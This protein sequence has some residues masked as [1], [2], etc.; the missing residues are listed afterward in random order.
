MYAKALYLAECQVPH[1]VREPGLRYVK[2]G[3]STRPAER[4]KTLQ[5]GNPF[6]L[7]II[8]CSERM[9]N[10]P[11][12][13]RLLHCFLDKKMCRQENPSDRRHNHWTADR[14]EWFLLSSEQIAQIREFV[15]NEEILKNLLPGTRIKHRNGKLCAY[16]ESGQDNLQMLWLLAQKHAEIEKMRRDLE[17]RRR[18]LE[19]H[20]A[21]SVSA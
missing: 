19:M 14:T 9:A 8:F 3:V 20:S 21:A 5:I 15:D 2:I 18:Q 6:P 16:S 10:A 4:L 17:R 1:D 13:E 7:R 12:V 11:T